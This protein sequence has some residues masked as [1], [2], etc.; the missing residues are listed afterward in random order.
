MVRNF[1]PRPIAAELRERLLANALRGPSAGFTQ[2]FDLLVLEGPEQLGRLWDAISPDRGFAARGWP[3]VYH[4][5]LVVVPLAHK[6]AYLSRYAES[7]KGWRDRDEARWP[8]P[9]WHVDAA[10]ASMLLLLTAVDL[11]LGALF[12]GVRDPGALR[13]AFGVPPDRDPIGAI[14]LGYAA[15]DRPSSSLRRGRRPL[16]EVVHRG[17]W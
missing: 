9:Y 15:P 4:A 6:A 8:V 16:E 11:G 14:A 17:G 10:F 5:P 3:G 2:G 12:F 1:E 13:G 7:D